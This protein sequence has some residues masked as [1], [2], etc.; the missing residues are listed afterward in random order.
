MTELF[1]QTLLELLIRSWPYAV[2]GGSTGVVVILSYG[3]GRLRE[4]HAWYKYLEDG[5]KMGAV[6]KEK[7][8]KRDKRVQ[9][10]INENT[11]IKG[12]ISKLIHQRKMALKLS[13][14]LSEIMSAN[15]VSE[16]I[17]SRRKRK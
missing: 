5:E 7:I 10:L 12:W 2:I 6:V 4:R 15:S 17:V 3:V 9:Q 13:L 11:R 14:D 1:G 8:D 16:D